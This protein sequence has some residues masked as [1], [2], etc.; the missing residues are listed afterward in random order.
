MDPATHTVWRDDVRVPLTN[1]AF[2]ILRVLVD[3][4]GHV[5]SKDAILGAV[6][7]DTY[8]HPDNVKVLIGEIRRGLGDDPS[9]PR[10]IRSIVKRGYI[11]IAPVSDSAELAP[12]H[13]PAFV[14]R[15]A[16]IERMMDA[17]DEASR[18]NRQFLFITGEAGIGKT[19]LCEA[20]LRLAATRHSLRATWAQC[21]RAT[22][23]SEPYHPLV[24]LL[25]RLIR[26]VDDETINVTLAR[27]APGWLPHLPGYTGEAW[28]IAAASG[29][30][31]SA[32][33][34][35]R[36]IVNAIE[37][38]AERSLLVIWIEDVHWADPATIDVLTALGQRTDPARLLI[39]ASARPPDAIPAA[40]PL[41]RAHADLVEHGRARAIRLQPFVLEEVERFL[42]TRF[43]EALDDGTSSILY[44]ATGGNP[45]FLASSAEHLVRKGYLVGARNTW[46]RN[47]SDDV[48]EATIPVSFAAA[49]VREFEELAPDERH[50]IASASVLGLEFPLWLAAQAAAGD[51]LAIEP[52]LEA[53]ARRQRFI[54]REGVVELA[55]GMFSPMYR[56]RHSLYQ[57]IVYDRT[58]QDLRSQAHERAGLAT[59]RLFAGRET[60]AAADLAWHFHRAGDHGRAARYF[61][62]AAANGLKRYAPREAAALLHGA[63]THAAHLPYDE[64]RR[65][66]LPVLLELGQAQLAA[67]ESALAVETLT[68]LDRRADEEHRHDDRLRAL[69]V[70]L[71]A[72]SGTSHRIELDLARTITAIAP[73]ATDETLAATALVRAGLTELIHDGWSDEIADRSLDTWR[74]LPRTAVDEHRSLAIRLLFVQTMRSQYA[75]AWTAGRK[76]LPAVVRSGNLSDCLAGCY[77]LA[78]AALHLG[79]WGDAVEVAAE[80][81]AIAER[82]GA[83]MFGVSMRLLQAWIAVEGRR[84]DEARQLCVS[85]RALAE[86]PGCKIPLQMSLLFGG[87][88][89]L[90]AGDLDAA[91]ADLERLRAWYTRERIVL[92]WLLKPQ[93]H[94][95][96]ADLALRRGHLERAAAEALAAQQAANRTP[97]RTW[98]ARALVTGAQVAIAR[99]HFEDAERCLRQ[100]RREIRGLEAPLATWQIE[101]VM[102]VLLDKT[103]QPDSAR[104]ARTRYERTFHRLARSIHEHQLEPLTQAAGRFP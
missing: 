77:L 99:G 92:D 56:F 17:L 53:L 66:E 34:M 63:L 78:L 40:G 49:V 80:G 32:A 25:A 98:R 91:E 58:G 30:M 10:F 42:D 86:G 65:I 88:A 55:N 24:D 52:V 79:R 46:T 74:T 83:S 29:Q 103:A 37:A 6:W 67:G 75:A 73:R 54:V 81:G 12:P 11:F 7:P 72:H 61:R 31:A 20:F 2:E 84:W 28:R 68:R 38:L 15:E 19:S 36:E 70:L 23:P 82:T 1:K 47:V 69:M 48:L 97:E 14:G 21:N 8:V 33:R 96:L 76:L 3:R 89:A 39:L 27:H 71:E 57:E 13:L 87:A 41:R 4:A 90:G 22:G 102:A 59:E 60:D 95:Y 43:G 101:A 35:F 100:A 104:R 9:S 51:E 45:L 18:S 62:L 94:G 44:R 93:L 26:S 16:E 5:V 50:A 85:D 64:R